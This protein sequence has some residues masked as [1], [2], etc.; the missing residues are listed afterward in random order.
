MTIDARARA[1]DLRERA[2]H[3][4]AH[5]R[6]LTERT[7][8]IRARLAEVRV[9]LISELTLVLMPSS[10]GRP[11]RAGASSGRVVRR[12]ARRRGAAAREARDGASDG[13]DSEPPKHDRA[14]KIWAQ[15]RVLAERMV[16]D[17]RGE[18]WMVR[19]LDATALPGA[20]VSRYLIFE[21]HRAVRK[22]RQYPSDWTQLGDATLLALSEDAP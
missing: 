15:A 3:A 7:A 14:A 8:A 10:A 12:S 22:L 16:Y 17:R 13:G 4:V 19:E 18:E 20:E 1:I 9:D 2:R 11:Q 21:N 6:E 5:S